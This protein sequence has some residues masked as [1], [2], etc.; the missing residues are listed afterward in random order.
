MS[1]VPPVEAV[2]T[3]EPVVA[4]EGKRKKRIY[5]VLAALIAVLAGATVLSAVI[6]HH[7]S[8]KADSS[9]NDNSGNVPARTANDDC[10]TEAVVAMNVMNGGN[11]MTLMQAI[12]QQSPIASI[13]T[14]LNGTWQSASIEVGRSAASD[15]IWAAA[16][17][18]C[19][20]QSN[21]L[22]TSAQVSDLRDVASSDG[23]SWLD[24]VENYGSGA[25]PAAVQQGQPP[26]STDTSTDSSTA[27]ST[28]TPAVQQDQPATSTDTESGVPV[29]NAGDAG[30]LLNTFYRHLTRGEYRAAWKMLSKS[31]RSNMGSYSG[32]AA[33]YRD[34]GVQSITNVEYV[35]GTDLTYRLTSDNPDGS[36]QRYDMEA[37]VVDGKITHLTGH[38]VSGS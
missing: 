2:I 11:Y 20:A 5:I 3:E 12:G 8:A 36:R 29:S 30:G 18:Q 10:S 15:K 23:Q 26:F 16:A 4:V 21:P 37:T 24:E 7:Q 34:S 9:S 35:N 22:L 38:Q 1:N 32:W 13:A 19:A 14:E 17:Q 25:A 33:G 27:T 31:A 6:T 28:D